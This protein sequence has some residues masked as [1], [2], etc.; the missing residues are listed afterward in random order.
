MNLIEDAMHPK[1]KLENIEMD[2]L[3]TKEW[4]QKIDHLDLVQIKEWIESPLTSQMKIKLFLR[5]WEKVKKR[6]I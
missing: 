4:I 5:E 6:E 2:F 1:L 3:E